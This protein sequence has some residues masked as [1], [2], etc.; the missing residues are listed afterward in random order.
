MLRNLQY[1]LEWHQAPHETHRTDR[2]V[3]PTLWAAFREGLAACRAYRQLR[4]R[5]LSHDIAIHDALDIGPGPAQATR[6]PA[7][8]LCFA[9]KI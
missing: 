2:S 9:G 8:P 3:L 7:K 1:R 6:A 5:G 4:Q